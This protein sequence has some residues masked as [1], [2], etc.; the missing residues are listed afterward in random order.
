MTIQYLHDDTDTTED[1]LAD[2]ERYKDTAGVDRNKSS[3]IFKQ[4]AEK[5]RKAMKLFIPIIV[6]I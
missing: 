6:S 1:D 4:A 3:E 2:G 5:K